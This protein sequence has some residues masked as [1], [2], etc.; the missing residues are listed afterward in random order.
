MDELDWAENYREGAR[1]ARRNMKACFSYMLE[2][3]DSKAEDLRSALLSWAEHEEVAAW[4]RDGQNSGWVQISL[5]FMYDLI[6]NSGV[7][8][9]SDKEQL[10]SW[11]AWSADQLIEPNSWWSDF[12]S[13]QDKTHTIEKEGSRRQEYDNW[14][15]IRVSCGMVCAMV[16]HDQS[17]VDLGF[18]SSVPSDYYLSDISE[19]SPDTRDLHNLI[20]GSVYPSGYNY[21]GYKRNYGFNAPHESYDDAGQPQA[22]SGQHYHFYSIYPLIFA[23]EAAMHNGANAFSY[24]DNALLRTFKTGSAWAD[25]ANRTNGSNDNWS[26]AYWYIY[27]RH[28]GDSDINSVTDQAASDY[29]WFRVG[30]KTAPIWGALGDID[31]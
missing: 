7:L 11:F 26:Q 3:S 18:N 25:N 19:Y 9:E 28:P 1:A 27:R 24:G 4:T 5:A 21:D 2:P 8:S 12:S 20:V 15:T 31:V 14:W 10:D 22:G 13:S 23:A 30:D 16:S 29:D 6:Y 17:L